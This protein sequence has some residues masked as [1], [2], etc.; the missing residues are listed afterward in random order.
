MRRLQEALAAQ[1]GAFLSGMH[2]FPLARARRCGVP[3]PPSSPAEQVAQRYTD[4]Q[5]QAYPLLGPEER[6]FL[7]RLFAA[8]Q[9]DAR[10]HPWTPT[11]CHGDLTSDHILVEPSRP[12]RIGGI[13][14]FGDVCLGDPATDF[15]WRYEYGDPFF[16]RVLAHYRGPLGDRAAFSRRVAYRFQLMAVI[17]LA[18]GVETGDERYIE[19]GRQRLR[20]QIEDASAARAGR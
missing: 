8:F 12:D 18:Y 14:D 16:A 5:A 3:E 4:A 15:V 2:T 19:E 10:A 1:V 9:T 6:A 7:D 11:L 20:R 13:I 17:E